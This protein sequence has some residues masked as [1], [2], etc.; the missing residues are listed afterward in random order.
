MNICTKQV[1]PQAPV[2]DD[3]VAGCWLHATGL[4]EE[5][6]T[7]LVRTGTEQVGAAPEL[8]G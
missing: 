5:A 4:D 3:H 6:R 8:A 2:G 7:P 1:P